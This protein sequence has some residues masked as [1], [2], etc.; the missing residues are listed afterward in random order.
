MVVY[1]VGLF[2]NF[3]ERISLCFIEECDLTHL[4]N[5]E[6]KKHCSKSNFDSVFPFSS[7]KDYGFRIQRKLY[8]KSIGGGENF[9]WA[10][11]RSNHLCLQYL[12]PFFG[13]SFSVPVLKPNCEIIIKCEQTCSMQMPLPQ[14]VHVCKDTKSP[15]WANSGLNMV[16]LANLLHILPFSKNMPSKT[17]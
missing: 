7:L 8:I 17:W 11:W 14:G 3:L 5:R 2:F 16:S 13:D 1:F 12:A 15:K 9:T 10:Y 6:F 4:H